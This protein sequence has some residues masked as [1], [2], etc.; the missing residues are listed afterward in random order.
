MKDNRVH[1]VHNTPSV[2]QTSFGLGQV[3]LNLALEQNRMGCDA[4]VWCL[5]SVED[6]CWA[7][8]LSD[9]PENKIVRFSTVG[10]RW[11]SY[12]PAMV[13]A[14]ESDSNEV[15][16]I[17]QHGIWTGVSRATLK[18]HKCQNVPTIIAPHGSLSHWALNIS[19]WKKW[20]AL[21][22]Y[23]RNNLNRASCLHATSENEISDF[24]DFGLTNPIAYIENGIQEKYLAVEG[25]A[26]RFLIQN[27]I[28]PDKH[29]LF[30]L[31]RISPKKGLLMLV[32][33]IYKIKND[34]IDWQLIIAGM[35]ELNHKV[36]VK[37]LIKQ[38]Q[39]EDK[40]KI[41]GPLFDQAKADAF[42]AVELFILPSYSEG[43]PMIVLESLAA[44][45]PVITT[46]A[47]TWSDLTV[48]N[49]GWWTDI[50]T[51][52]IAVALHEAV[53]MSAE[54]LQQMG[55][56]GK[57]L[58]ASKFTWSHLAQKTIRLYDWLLG[59]ADKPDF[60]ILD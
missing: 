26:E 14:A 49:C 43:F 10:P 58:I 16:A 42:A 60:V 48:Y 24:R 9:L 15:D 55:K 29:I 57:H 33:A 35:D 18:M 41:I 30:F 32:E 45:V 20:I 59:Q 25:N 5:S 46:K 36:Q 50:N 13:C 47:S 54:G 19:R 21:A 11:M 17:H 53:S 52:A 31:S 37:S 22:A 23:E 34:F 3:A 7:S 2:G 4:K 1:I 28:A 40:I 51:Q 44:G 56:R 38:L 8:A 12:S 27:N 6:V 39:L